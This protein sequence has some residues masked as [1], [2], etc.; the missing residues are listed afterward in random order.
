MKKTPKKVT[1][2]EQVNLVDIFYY[3]LSNWIWFV[4][5]VIIAL[6]IGYYLYA[7][8]PFTYTNQVKAIVKDPSHNTRS[9]R[10]ETYDSMINA[11]SVTDEELQLKSWTLMSEVV[12]ELNADVSLKQHIKFRD[13]E[14]YT[15]LAP[16][17]MRFSREEDDPGIF[18]A[19][20]TP[21]E[22]GILRIDAGADGMKVA[23]FGDTVSLGHGKVVFEPTYIYGPK[24][25]GIPIK[26]KRDDLV[27]TAVRIVSRLSVDHKDG[28]LTLVLKDENAQRV[29]DILNTLVV[30]YNEDAIREKNK[31]AVNTAKFIEERLQIIEE[32]LGGV[33]GSLASFQRSNQ[34][35]DVSEA[36]SNYLSESRS[37]NAEI[38][39]I[40]TRMS[41]ATHLRDHIAALTSAYQMIPAN[42]GLNDANIENAINVYN[43]QVMRR[44]KLILGSSTGSPAVKQI[45]QDM[46]LQ[47]HNIQGLIQ[48]LI[49]S[50]DMARKDL[51]RREEA[52]IR[53]YAA[54]PTKAKEM[55]E[56]ERQQ[57]IKE[58]LYIFLL[59]KR[60]EN[61]LSQAMADD[62]IRL[63]DPSVARY[64]PSSP[65]RMKVAM[66]ALLAGI[67][68][69]FVILIARL[70]LDTKIRT[71]KEIEENIDVPF[72]A[73]IPLN[74]DLRHFIWQAKHRRKG[75]K[76]PSPFVYESSSHS[77]FTEAMRMMCTNLNFLDPDCV[78]PMVV[79]TTSYT[80]SSGKTFIV[81]NMAACLAD[82]QKRVIVVDIDMRKRSLSGE[83]GLKH[84]TVGLSN[85]IYDLDMSV[86]DLIHKDVK[87]G[88]DFIPAG[89]TPP[90][91]GELLS[92]P[93]FDDLIKQLRTRY[94]Y[95]LLD[96]VPIQ[97][98]S[99]PLIVNRVVDCNLFILRSGQLDRRILPQLD[100]LNEN[101][102]LT[103]MAIVFNGPEVKH[104]RGW[105][106]GSYGY[107]Y[108]YGYGL[109]STY[110][111]EEEQE[112]NV[113]KRWFKKKKK[114]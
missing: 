76:E 114:A 36:A 72:L 87:P 83:L 88:I 110:Y 43:E 64:A 44:E 113:F 9:A 34:L 15:S 82:A 33:E 2:N 11:I 104:R 61:A 100:E 78:P 16:F 56:I 108:G 79:G 107:G 60:E 59:N 29:A 32:E 7:R 10:L 38:V 97:M 35:M 90:N 30:K 1:R 49:N 21:L 99:E 14:L 54:M 55:L 17:I 12:K 77:V 46:M 5:S 95:I 48:N 57:S 105:G 93:R 63:V 102:H 25:Y 96:G 101:R 85:Y 91:P 112:K 66:L 62:N 28:I 103:N 37:Y 42:T 6:G 45:E 39:E 86:D 51:A 26:I 81:A 75:Q 19:T 13:V 68:V 27:N 92:R 70:F 94:D 73:E 80:S 50:L 40:E 47:R 69:P 58:A 111:G 71:R 23:A 24:N 31:V 84:K 18:E 98:L 20:V 52:S 89:S 106:F 22:G 65:Q 53:K 74:K 4:I 3:L 109:A 8:V 67:L 41:L